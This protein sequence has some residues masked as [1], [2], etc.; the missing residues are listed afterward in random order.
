MPTLPIL[1]VIA[2]LGQPASPPGTPG[3]PGQN[4]QNNRSNRNMASVSERFDQLDRNKDGVLTSDEVQRKALF[5]RADTNKDGKIT[6]EEAAALANNARRQPG[7]NNQRRP[8]QPGQGT[9]SSTELQ[10]TRDVPYVTRPANRSK[11][12]LDIYAHDTG[13]PKPV[14]IYIH[15]GGWSGGDKTPGAEDKA[16]LLAPQGLMLVS[17]NYRLSP[18]VTHP[19][20]VQDVAAA[21]AWVHDNIDDYGGDPD[22]MIVMGHSAG[23][24]LAALVAID[25]KRLAAHG[26]SLDIL[27]GAILLDGAAYDLPGMLELVP[28]RTRKTHERWATTNPAT[29]A[30]ASPILQIKA[31]TDI[32]PFL[33][34]HI[35]R[36][37]GTRQSQQLAQ[38]LDEVGVPSIVLLCEDETHGSMNTDLGTPD[39]LPT[40]A[41]RLVLEG[42]NGR[43]D[44]T[45]RG[46]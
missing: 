28:A 34:L 14:M 24:H 16:K 39:H 25:P 4:G 45:P 32:P 7:R 40:E 31:N 46:R 1:L 2:L 22:R 33:I 30:D 18:A 35:D 11:Q 20:H 9:R 21:V 5:T 42:L 44:R 13:T 8:E 3:G 10:I 6:R 27:D 15:G 43:P 41:I 38:R 23:A 26:K 37:L 19:A 36:E 29:Q 12:S 17:I